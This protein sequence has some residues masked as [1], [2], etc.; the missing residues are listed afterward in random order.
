MNLQEIANQISLLQKY[1]IETGVR[2]SRSQ[3]DILRPLNG[4]ETVKV[5]E[6]VRDMAIAAEKAGR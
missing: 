4:A 6:L 2:T 5:I 1:S 3:A